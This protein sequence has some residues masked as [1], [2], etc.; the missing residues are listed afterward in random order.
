MSGSFRPKKLRQQ[1][2][3]TELGV[4]SGGRRVEYRAAYR[5]P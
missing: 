3:G 2:I 1:I 5:L 4:Y